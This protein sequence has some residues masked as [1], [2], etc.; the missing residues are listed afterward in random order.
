MRKLGKEIKKIRNSMNLSQEEFAQKIG[1]TGNSLKNA[2]CNIEKGRNTISLDKLRLIEAMANLK[3]EPL[4]KLYFEEK[5]EDYGEEFDNKKNWRDF[6]KMV[7]CLSLF[8]A[9]I[10]P[11]IDFK[12]PLNIILLSSS[13]LPTAQD[14]LC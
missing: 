1:F 3:D 11:E 9:L 10:L 14:I 12:E 5:L 7:S 13:R 2:I 8:F 6:L 4:K